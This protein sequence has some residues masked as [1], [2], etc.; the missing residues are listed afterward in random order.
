MTTDDFQPPH[1]AYFEQPRSQPSG[2]KIALIIV[3]GVLA[4]CVVC[5]VITVVAGI[6]NPITP[7]PTPIW[8]PAP[9]I[10]VSPP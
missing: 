8:T 9:T 2:V 10:S 7:S 3:L 4:L 5:G 6:L 1:V